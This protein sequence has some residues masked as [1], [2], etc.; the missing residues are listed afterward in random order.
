MYSPMCIFCLFANFIDD[1]D[2]YA[3]SWQSVKIKK[4]SA[5]FQI[6]IA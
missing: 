2:V 3:D 5:E 6:K 4:K 1:V